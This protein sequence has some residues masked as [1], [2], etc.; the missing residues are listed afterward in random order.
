MMPTMRTTV[1]IDPDVEAELRA[2]MRERGVSF[3][4]AVNDALR[5]GLG[6]RAALAPPFRVKSAPLGARFNIDKALTVAGEMEDEEIVR[7]LEMGK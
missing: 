5:A 7:K 1:T 4:L 2:V 6:T 3:K